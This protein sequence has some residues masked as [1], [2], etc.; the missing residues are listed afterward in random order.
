MNFLPAILLAVCAQ[1]DAP[2]SLSAEPAQVFSGHSATVY[3]VDSSP[4]GSLVATA[5]FDGTV[6]LWKVADGAERIVFS[7][8][9]G[10]VMSVAFS[11]DGRSLVSGG[12][13]KTVKLWEVPLDQGLAL[14]E[15][16]SPVRAVVLHEKSGRLVTAGADGSLRIWDLAG[17]KEER[18]LEPA[19]PGLRTLAVDRSGTL[20]A[21]AG[22]DRIVRIWNLAPPARVKKKLSMEGTPLVRPGEKWRLWRGKTAPPAGWNAGTFDASAWELLPSGFGYGTN[23]AELKTVT[24]RL[25]GMKQDRQQAGTPGYLSIFVRA[26]FSIPDP[27]L[28]SKLILKVAFDDGFVAFLNGREV[29]RSGVRGNPPGFRQGASAT[30]AD[31]VEKQFDLTPHLSKLKA[32]ENLLAL[33]GH[34]V[35]TS[36]SDFVLSPSLF[37]VLP[38]SPAAQEKPGPLKLAGSQGEIRGVDFSLDGSRLAAVGDDRMVRIWRL[39]DGQEIVR[40]Q[41]EAAGRDLV[42]IDN[43]TLAVAGADG[44]V[45]IWNISGE[46]ILRSLAGHVGPVLA[47]DWLPVA[48]KLASAGKDG[49][50]RL[51]DSDRGKELYKLAGHEGDVLSLSFSG[52]G[53]Q[54]VSGGADKTLRIWAVESGKAQGKF[55]HA[56]PVRAVAAAP[57][58]QYY[59]AA[60]GNSLVA[61][62]R[63]SAAAVRTL[64]GHGGFVHAVRFSPDG[65][66][67]ASAGQDKSVRTWRVAD[68][69]AL[70]TIK[71]HDSTVYALAFSPGGQQLCSGSFD[72]TIK[73]WN[74]MNGIEVGRFVGHK[75][76]VFCLD[77]SADGQH[78]FSGSSDLT[79]RRWEV[80]NGKELSVYE[81]H[82]GWVTGLGLRP[83]GTQLISAD[84][85]GTLLTWNV[86][87]GR[88]LARRR[89][90]PVIY[91][92]AV[93][94]DGK[95]LVTANPENTALLL[96]Q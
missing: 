9:K 10:K 68:G 23:P 2:P 55:T 74:A 1:V 38:T 31:A 35:N 8:H 42:F 53:K 64:T 13:D 51:W 71:A 56:M 92:I 72:K 73:L 86:A 93:F 59:A 19:A 63:S 52:N 18:V 83:S 81:G 82:G 61:W 57:G 67:I 14:A 36:S 5:S 25:D 49:T 11:P 88:I 15:Q 85:S 84:Y 34:N 6:K 78:L 66:M 50:V 17:R 28:A 62:K 80:K 76:G 16:L 3:A 26:K 37:A 39:S 77:F 22:S 7:G 58:E 21:A 27:S 32:G 90:R 33:Q 96:N 60:E 43:N 87:D 29:V 4:D 95:K 94:A 24:T 75:E 41:G 70:L 45:A 12:E 48:R 65:R 47:V 54:L 20:V 44:V 89:A 91:G 40:L 79:I 69:A 46:K 30:V